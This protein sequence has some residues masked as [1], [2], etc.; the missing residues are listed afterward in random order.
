MQ[1]SETVLGSGAL[2][3]MASPSREGARAVEDRS[4]VERL[5]EPQHWDGPEEGRPRDSL[6]LSTPRTGGEERSPPKPPSVC[7]FVRWFQ[8]TAQRAH[9]ISAGRVQWALTAPHSL[10][11]HAHHPH[12]PGISARGSGS[13]A[14][15]AGRK[16]WGWLLTPVALLEW[17][18]VGREPLKGKNP[19]P[20]L[21]ALR[22]SLGSVWGRRF[23]FLILSDLG[24]CLDSPSPHTPVR[25]PR[26]PDSPL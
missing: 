26:A 14:K 3:P 22:G 23:A 8:E 24:P 11:S 1:L 9:P 20:L 2:P 21:L 15:V 18:A 7:L 10:S 17:G 4:E 6:V 25:E 16:G 5:L 12:G 13:L 19:L